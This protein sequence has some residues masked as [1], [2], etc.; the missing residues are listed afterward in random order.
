VQS[1]IDSNLN[2]DTAGDR[3]Y[4]NLAGQGVSHSDA[5]ALTNSGGQTVGYLANDPSAKYIRAR[6][7]VFPNAGRSTIPMGRINNWDLNLTKRFNFTERV[8]FELRGYFL[9]GFNHP[10]YT[11]GFPNTALFKASNQTRN[12]LIP[13]NAIFGDYTQVFDSNSRTMQI[14][15]R[16][17]F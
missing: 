3:A 15:A 2:G 1:N 16:L 10:Q 11:P 5:T 14:V 4:I 12:H 8:R 6:P 13:G 17:T 9:N 7:G